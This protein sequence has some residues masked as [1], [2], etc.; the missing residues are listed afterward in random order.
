MN[1]SELQTLIMAQATEKGFG[2]TPEDIVVSEKIALIHSEVTEAFEAYR[3]KKMRGKDGFFEELGDIV[4]RVLH[5][6]GVF[7]VDIEQEIR[8][9]VETNEHREWRWDET[10][11]RHQ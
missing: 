6:A 4:Q 5:L 11:E 7:G 10:N 3:H 9:K 1:I 8:S 2:T